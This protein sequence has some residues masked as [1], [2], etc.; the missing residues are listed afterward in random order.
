[1]MGVV[2]MISCQEMEVSTHFKATT[3]IEALAREGKL[4]ELGEEHILR[5]LIRVGVRVVI[6]STLKLYQEQSILS[7]IG[8]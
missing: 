2:G 7:R 8:L 1:M 5:V 3:T 4:L 6:S